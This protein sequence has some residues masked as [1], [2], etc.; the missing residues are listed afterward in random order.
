MANLNAN[1]LALL[2]TPLPREAIKKVD[3]GSKDLHSIKPIFITERLNEIFGVGNWIVKSEII[4]L[5]GGLPYLEDNSGTSTRFIVMVKVEFSIPEHDIYYECIA[6]STNNDIGDSAKGAIS[7]CISKIA[8]WMGIAAEVYKGNH[9]DLPV[10]KPGT[11]D[12]TK[13]KAR[14]TQGD[15][16][17]VLTEL[18]EEYTITSKMEDLLTR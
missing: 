12:W 8:S 6:S 11:P 5:E 1:Q 14:L 16:N 2:N 7:D 18:R 10:L 17:E 13:A 9:K 3:F 4:P 15:A